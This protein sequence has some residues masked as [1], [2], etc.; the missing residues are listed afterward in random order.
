M[1][2]RLSDT[3][4]ERDG[5]SRSNTGTGTLFA[6]PACS[7]IDSTDDNHLDSEILPVADELGLN[8]PSAADILG[9]TL[10][11]DAVLEFFSS[12]KPDSYFGSQVRSCCQPLSAQVA[13]NTH[14]QGS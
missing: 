8:L 1:D 9:P 3:D 11:V 5:L 7:V 4:G 14:V 13:A 12:D 2:F 6:S 10:D